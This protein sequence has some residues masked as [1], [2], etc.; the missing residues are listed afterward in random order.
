MP[1]TCMFYSLLN[2]I[3]NVMPVFSRRGAIFHDF[4]EIFALLEF[5]RFWRCR[6][7]IVNLG[8][9]FPNLGNTFSFYVVTLQSTM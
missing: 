5:R 4:I 6:D 3:G 9:H 7:E 2:R 8:K 1:D